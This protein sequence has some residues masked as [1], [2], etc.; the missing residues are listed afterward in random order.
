MANNGQI[1]ITP[2]TSNKPINKGFHDGTGYVVGDSDLVSGNIKA[3]INIFGVDGKASVV[4]TAVAT[5]TSDTIIS[6]FT[7]WVNG[8]KLTG[9]AKGLKTAS[10]QLTFDVST[11]Y[12]ISFTLPTQDFNVI[13][14]IAYDS[15]GNL[16][17]K[18]IFGILDLN[19]SAYTSGSSTAFTTYKISNI[20][21]YSWSGTVYWYAIGY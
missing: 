4:D 14:W 2:T 9:N 11:N 19:I 17:D 5:A 3:G 21:M 10:G 20:P 18:G 6:G 7:A 15:T 16:N 12:N 1:I 13:A 8:N